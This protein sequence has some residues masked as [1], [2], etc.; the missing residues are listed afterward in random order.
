MPADS[1]DIATDSAPPRKRNPFAIYAD[2]RMAK[3]LLL[4]FIQGFPWLLIASMLSLWLKEE[5]L[6]RTGIGFFGVVFGV[7]AI[8]V[9]WSPLVDGVRLPLLARWLGTRRAWVVAMQG[10]I[11]GMML[12]LFFLPDAVNHLWWISLFI[13]IIALASAT[14]DIALDALRI[15]LIGEDEPEKIGAG[16]AMMVSGWWLG[17]GG[18]K[19]AAFPFVEW[20][21]SVGVMSAWQVTYLSLIIVIALSVLLFIVFVRTPDVEA[22][23]SSSPN[24][25]EA[26]PAASNADADAVRAA[27]AAF[28]IVQLPAR[29]LQLYINPIRSFMH[30]YTLRIAL[31]LLFFIF[32]FKIGEA[33]L[34]RMSLIFYK[35]IGFTTSEIGLLSGGL[36]TLTICVFSIFGSFVNAY[37]GLF[38]GIVLGGIAMAATNLLFAA[39]AVYPEKWLFVT[40][41]VSDQFTTAISTV[42]FVA[43]ISQLCDRTYT[44]T[45]YAALGS[46]GN[47]SRTTLAASSG[48]LVD[49]LGGNWSLFFVITVVMVLPSLFILFF[50]RRA[51]APIMAGRT[52][53]L[54]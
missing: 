12:C 25:K 52:T 6:S 54:L 4:G 5:G 9:L 11:A 40:A 32:F 51:I 39:L 26:P 22:K 41:V 3:I 36:G 18:G 27:P 47:L 7:Y 43:F 29:F 17:F 46:L 15:E 24:A 20:L 21:Q 19:A 49:G 37:Y 23:P 30:R 1:A 44:A 35:E 53:R 45:Q 10:V 13:F 14:Q 28:S 33:F 16:S 2:W 48:L 50:A 42:A 31:M 34:G 38:R 8:N